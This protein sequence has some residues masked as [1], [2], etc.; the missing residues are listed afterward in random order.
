[1]QS[2]DLETAWTLVAAPRVNPDPAFRQSVESVLVAERLVYR[3]YHGNNSLT[4]IIRCRGTPVPLAYSIFMMSGGRETYIG[5]ACFVPGGFQTSV[6]I[7]GQIGDPRDDALE[8]VDIVFRPNPAVAS[9][10]MTEIW[11]GEVILRN[12]PVAEVSPALAAPKR[13]P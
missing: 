11:G 9:P 7:S 2:I 13:L 4:G 12:V 6:T 1:V 8:T 10:D 5:S 3:P